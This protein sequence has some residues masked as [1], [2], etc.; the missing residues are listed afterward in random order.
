MIGLDVTRRARATPAR[1]AAIEAL[2]NP[3]AAAVAGM[4]RYSLDRADKHRASGLPIHD[5]LVPAYLLRPDFFKARPAHLRVIAWGETDLGRSVELAGEVP[6]AMLVTRVD[7]DGLF[8]LLT[9]RL[10]HYA[11]RPPK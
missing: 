11:L 4:L 7:A 1:I 2:G 5:L 6:N 8:T 3:V 10:K 9:D